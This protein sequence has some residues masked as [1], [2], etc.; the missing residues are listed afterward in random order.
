MLSSKAL[1]LRRTRGLGLGAKLAKHV[2]YKSTSPWQCIWQLKQKRLHSAASMASSSDY[3]DHIY[4]AWR[5][6]PATVHTSWREYFHAIE[7]GMSVAEP[8]FEPFGD[9]NSATKT[10]SAIPRLDSHDH[11]LKIDRLVRAYQDFGHKKAQ[12]NPLN[13]PEKRFSY[14]EVLSPESHG[15]TEADMDHEVVLGP[16]LLPHF[17]SAGSEKMTLREIIN[18]CEAVYCGTIGAEYNH[19]A[20]REEREWIRGRLETPRPYQ[21]SSEEKK[22]ILDRLVWT[23]T[24]EKFMSAKFPNAK[25]FSIEGVESQVPALKAVIDASAENGVENIIFPCCHRGKLNVLSNVGRKP[26]ELIF[27]EFS[28]DSE[29]RHDISGDVK[30]HLGINYDRQT[31]TGKTVN[32]SILPNPSHLEAQNTLGQGMARAIQHQNSRNRSSTMV[33]NSHTDASFSGQGVIYETL[34]LS[35]LKH[36]E[37]GGTVHLIINNQVGFT[38]NPDSA[39]TSPYASDIAKSI[40]APIFHVNADDVEAVVF[41]CKL[42]ADYRAN[43]GK[44]CWVDMICYRKHGHNEMDQ[45]FFT[46]PQMYK[47]IEQKVPHLDSYTKKL[48]QEGVIS[49]E[50]VKKMEMHVWSQMSESLEKSKSPE[51]V[52]GEYLTAPWVGMK[53]PA[54]VAQEVLLAKSTAVSRDV[55][56][57]VAGKLGIPEKPFEVHKSLR[58]ILQKRQQSLL[59]GQDIDW[60]TAEA[61][62]MGSLCLEGHH[63]RVSG[64]D[65]ERGTFSQRHAVLHDQKTGATYLPLNDLGPEQAEFSIG[66]SSLSEYGVMGFDYGYSCSYPNALVMWEAQFGDFANNAQCI[67]DQ[68][69]SSAE[70][71]WLLRSG[72]VLSL[73][74]G[75]D[76]QGP[77]HSSA[78]LERFLQ[79]CSEDSRFFPTE[80]QLQRQHQ[81]AN[82]Q[83]VQMTTPANLFHVLRRQLHRDFR[84]RAF[85]TIALILFFSK[86]LLRHP[87]VK[88]RIDDFT[89]DSKFQPLISD[90]AHGSVISEPWGVKRVIYC[91]GQVYFTLAKYRE[92]HGIRDTAITRIEQLHPFPWEQTRDNLEQYPNASDIVW[93]QEESLNDGP[94]AFA[95]TRLE[96]IFDTTNRHQGRRLR[97][98]GREATPSV[99]TG[100]GKVH[101]AQEAALLKEA[102]Q[103]S[104]GST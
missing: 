65:V 104:N 20:T 47:Q 34:G 23:A 101:R 28:P 1:L 67:I 75:F 24:F 27:S 91:T 30:Y 6:D 32:L 35:G 26:N 19:V 59:D 13:L 53:T 46:Q 87:S 16:D 7:N 33:L 95:R 63:V 31:P 99:A 86:S 78:R 49:L 55:V 72:L 12:T 71:K 60:A 77:E 97:F 93:C 76:G 102:F 54:E 74:H 14:L 83:V 42:A 43:F 17:A 2:G 82:M 41:L 40:D 9:F 68:F 18:A 45:P 96:T 73:P 98:A 51:A 70:N 3:L 50:E 29:S 25:R 57:T 56:H 15:L 80:Q 89:G 69:I 10:T 88:S 11:R 21:F 36:Y 103:I 100:F 8:V 90:P 22:R 39:R 61:L 58:R 4:T 64:Q 52:E 94:W 48:V 5:D 81:D 66:N 62:A 84:K 92:T 38:T 85:L 37:T 79:L 44:D